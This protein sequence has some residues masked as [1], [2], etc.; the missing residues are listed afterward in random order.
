MNNELYGSLQVPMPA[1]YYSGV[2]TDDINITVDNDTREISATITEKL[3]GIFDDI[4]KTLDTLKSEVTEYVSTEL[5]KASAELDSQV[6]NLQSQ[7]SKLYN[8][9]ASVE[10][11]LTDIKDDYQSADASFEQDI[12]TLN[13]DLKALE[14]KSDLNYTNIL[15]DI[16]E[17]KAIFEE[18]LN[19]QSSQITHLRNST[20]SS[21]DSVNENISNISKDIDNIQASKLNSNGWED[22]I[23]GWK[24]E[25][26]SFNIQSVISPEY[27]Q[28]QEMEMDISETRI[29]GGRILLDRNFDGPYNH[30]II[31]PGECENDGLDSTTYL[32][33]QGI[34]YV[35]RDYTNI[36]RFPER[37]DDSY[38][39]TEN[40]G[41]L[42]INDI[43]S[44]DDSLLKSCGWEALPYPGNSQGW[45]MEGSNS[46][47]KCEI[48]CRTNSLLQ[49]TESR[50][51]IGDE[52]NN[53]AELTGQYLDHEDQ[54]I[55]IN[56]RSIEFNYGYYYDPYNRLH[57]SG[58]L[59]FP[60]L[61]G[62]E[63]TIATEDQ[64]AE[65]LDQRLLAW[66][67]KKNILFLDK[68]GIQRDKITMYEADGS[69]GEYTIG[70]VSVRSS[71]GEEAQLHPD[72]LRH[73]KKNNNGNITTA[74]LFPNRTANSLEYIATD[75]DIAKLS[76]DINTL[77]TAKL[78]ANGWMDNQ[79]GW[80]FEHKS[81][82]F[83][84]EID[85]I[86]DPSYIQ[87]SE[88][89]DDQFI[90]YAKLNTYSLDIHVED[91][92]NHDIK[93]S[94]ASQYPGDTL[95]TIDE[96]GIAYNQGYGGAGYLAF[97]P[98]SATSSNPEVI[99]TEKYVNDKLN[100]G[101]WRPTSTSFM[102]VEMTGWESNSSHILVGKNDN[103]KIRINPF[104]IYTE[105][106]EAHS[107]IHT[108]SYNRQYLPD[109][110]DIY[111]NRITYYVNATAEESPGVYIGDKWIGTLFFP[112]LD[113]KEDTIATRSDLDGK[114]DTGSLEWSG[115]SLINC[116]YQ[117][118]SNDDFTYT[119]SSVSIGQSH[120][121]ITK[122]HPGQGYASSSLIITDS[123]ITAKN[124]ADEG[125]TYILRS[126][127]PTQVEQ[128]TTATIATLEELEAL[129]ARIQALEEKLS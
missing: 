34:K 66:D 6:N 57:Y 79:N 39:L 124:T 65:K 93:L 20:K 108:G 84:L 50:L 55:L 36:L 54:K 115:N 31:D 120:I 81:E 83:E 10:S 72:R 60:Q 42:L 69:A 68:V 64:V 88:L 27:I 41:K 103:T 128:F 106:Y 70:R 61:N 15:Q 52:Y 40:T 71:T 95:L 85:S 29:H 117:R 123:D 125:V 12:S 92:Y 45:Q 119:A 127:L 63:K 112:D 121:Y 104:E 4:P 56:P 89:S 14:E 32:G 7:T 97:P 17:S 1:L 13:K 90:S 53:K 73:I 111:P 43:T 25:D 105:A 59:L 44:N 51:T 5:D 114:L 75:S 8:Q 48:S 78:N 35:T 33:T 113:G 122:T 3:M 80:K 110:L 74:L 28:I 62:E 11:D 21:F 118:D 9:I 129:E 77:Q 47:E 82:Q 37:D 16:D 109:T 22:R 24:F 101:T 2:D 94:Y 23:N 26:N 98:N 100:A 86:L 46:R 91:G 96:I 126:Y 18:L 38:I 107:A 87:V 58:T 67:T 19:N 99:A 30:I 49:L 116:L 102:H 76:Q